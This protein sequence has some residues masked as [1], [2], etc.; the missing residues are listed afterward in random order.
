M[1]RF[2]GRAVSVKV[3]GV[4]GAG[5]NA[6]SRMAREKRADLEF[7]C[8]NTD[9]QALASMPG[10]PTFAI[11][12]DL[13][14]GL[15]S[16]GNPDLGRRAIRESQD[17]LSPL[18][19]GADLV[20]ITAGM[21]GGTG[22]GAAPVVAEIARKQ[23][24]LTVAVVTRPFSFEGP[25]RGEIA[26]KGVRRL[27][28]KVDTMITV[29]NDS[30]LTALDGGTSLDNAFTIADQ[31][32]T[33]GVNG[34]SDIVTLPGLINVDFA[35]VRSVLNYGGPSF[36]AVGEGK[37]RRA[38]QYALSAA[39]TSPL[40]PA[41]IKGAQ[42]VLLNIRGGKELSLGEVN[43]MAG[44]LRS[45]CG[46]EAHVVLGVVQDQDRKW[47]KR[48]SVT[49]VA[50]GLS[51]HDPS[52]TRDSATTFGEQLKRLE[53]AVGSSMGSNNGHGGPAHAMHKM[54]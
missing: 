43:D 12:P 50:T 42:G 28:P 32:L 36:M 33:Q 22:T 47:K 15:G 9:I 37:G 54:F 5:N 13:T 39:L 11:G 30:L 14:R 4:G 23:G 25:R 53:P 8:V 29:E 41:P 20:F 38:G 27:L 31:V 44:A 24:A 6:V 45:A 35:D 34:I 1:T 2:P 18:I 46:P 21:G 52:E 48:V 17:Q 7:L 19:A 40:F 49:I 3:I 26:D 10:L 51:R 16:G